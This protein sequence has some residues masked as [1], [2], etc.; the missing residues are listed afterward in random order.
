[1]STSTVDPTFYRSPAEAIAAPPEKLA[2]VVTFDR[3]GEQ[4]DAL[5]VI[6]TDPD[7]A[8]YG[9]VVGWSDLPTRGDELHHF[10]WNACSSAF[11]HAGHHTDGLQRRYLL[12]PGLRSSNIHVYDTHPDP[13]QPRLVRT[14]GADELAARAGY[15]RPHTLH[16]GPDGIYLSCLGVADGNGGPG[17][18]AVLDHDT[19]EVVR[20]WETDR[21]P[22][23]LAYDAW[24]HLNQNTLITSEWGTPSMIEDGLVPELLLGNEYGHALHFWDLAEGSHAQRV[25]LGAEHQMVLELRP[26]HDPDATWGFAGVVISTEDLSASV[27]RW[28]RDGDQWRADKVITIP[29]EPAEADQLPPAL[30]PF[31]AVPP[32]VTDINLTVDD[33]F[34]YVSC[35]GTGELKQYDVS[36]P[37]QP[38]ETGSVRLGGIVGRVAHP[39]A[40][41]RALAGGPQMVEVSRDGQRIYLTNSLYGAW[42]DQFYPDGVGAW[43]A[44]VTTDP[45]SGGL[46]VDEGFFLHG[47]DFRGRRAHQVRLQ[48]GDASSDSYC[49]AGT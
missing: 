47:E 20:A 36:D 15:S 6:G 4:P 12:L 3:A 29:A 39:S 42:D 8:G 40:P 7:S 17:G 43:L 24:W 38:R 30:Q 32:L 22:Q 37:A 31:G 9:Q 10:G 35:W 34:L 41:G 27:W 48:G 28:Y 49:Y 26:S 19:F 18:I 16:C 25:D 5:A 33:R 11:A 2:Y 23:H 45:Q 21:G 13:E 14:I 46:S 44:K 1:M